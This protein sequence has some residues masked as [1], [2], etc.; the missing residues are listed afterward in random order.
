[1]GKIQT[2]SL[3]GFHRVGNLFLGK[4]ETRTEIV[5]FREDVKNLLAPVKGGPVGLGTAGTDDGEAQGTIALM[6]DNLPLLEGLMRHL[7]CEGMHGL[8]VKGG[9]QGYISNAKVGFTPFAWFK[10]IHRKSSLMANVI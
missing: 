5:V 7:G 10:A 1:M 6:D 3:E 4:Q 8:T 9:K 2:L